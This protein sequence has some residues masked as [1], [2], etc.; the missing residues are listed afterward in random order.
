MFSIYRVDQTGRIR[1]RHQAAR[2]F[3][4]L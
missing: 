2:R 1:F 4:L 3:R